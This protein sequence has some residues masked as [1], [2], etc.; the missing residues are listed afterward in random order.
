[1][2]N[3]AEIIQHE[4]DAAIESDQLELPTLPEVALRIRDAAQQQDIS[5]RN[6]ADVVAEDAGLA[7]TN[8]PHASQNWSEIPAFRNIGLDPEF[9]GPELE[10]YHEDVEQ[11]KIMLA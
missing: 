6:L 4:L 11:A 1:M 8:H 9:E 5:P 3:T 2:Q 10:G 7:G